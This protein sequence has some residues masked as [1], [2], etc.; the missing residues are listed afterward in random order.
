ALE[1]LAEPRTVSGLT[2]LPAPRDPRAAAV[3][4]FERARELQSL[5]DHS[6]ARELLLQAQGFYPELTGLTEALAR[7][8]TKLQTIY[9]SKIGKLRA[10]PRARLQEGEGM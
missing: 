6:G 5:D 3:R 10:V 1:L 8:E 7:S 9:E 4:L 2:P